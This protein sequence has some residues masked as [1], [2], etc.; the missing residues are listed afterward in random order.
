MKLM[1]VVSAKEALKRLTASHF[2]NYKILRKLV[3]LRKAVDAEVEFYAEAEKRAVE[4]F[5][6]KDGNG[7]PIFLSD[8][9]LKLKSPADKIAFESEIT[10][11]GE[12]AVDGIEPVLIHEADFLSSSELPTPEDILLLDGIVIFEE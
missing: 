10:K 7:N 12:T 4:Q 3:Q 5:A 11:L 8:G 2:S 6:E 9:R 1:K